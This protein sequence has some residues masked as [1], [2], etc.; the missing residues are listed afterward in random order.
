MRFLQLFMEDNQ[1][2][3]MTIQERFPAG[4]TSRLVVANALYHTC[5]I[6]LLFA[7]ISACDACCSR[8]FTDGSIRGYLIENGNLISK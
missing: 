8:S 7:N 2:E 1:V 4:E 6:P 3:T 5:C